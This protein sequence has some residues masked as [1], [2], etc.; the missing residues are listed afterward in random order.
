MGIW[1]ENQQGT[2]PVSATIRPKRVAFLVDKGAVTNDVVNEIVRFNC[3]QWGGRFNPIIPTD[4]ASISE[5]WWKLLIAVDPDIIY[6]SL[7][8]TDELIDRINRRI[9]PVRI[10]EKTPEDLARREGQFGVSEFDVRSITTSAMPRL[11][12][13]KRGPLG[14]PVFYLVSESKWRDA[15][16]VFALRNFGLV[17]R[18]VTTAT[19]F[20]DVPHKE[21]DASTATITS[22][23]ALE[24]IPRKRS[25][26]PLDLSS[27]FA[28][29]GFSLPYEQR[30]RGFHLV[31]GDTPW[32]AIYFWNLAL[33]ER[34]NAGREAIWLPATA[35]DDPALL[36][37][38]GN[39]IAAAF[40]GDHDDRAG[41]I[42]SYS[43][44]AD[45]LEAAAK[46][47]LPV[48]RIQLKPFTPAVGEHP[49]P[50]SFDQI[51]PG[52]GRNVF[53]PEYRSTVT[54][55]VS[56]S[57]DGGLVGLLQPEFC[58]SN[59]PQ[60]GWMADLEIGYRPDRF[61]YTN[62]RPAWRLP[63]RVGVA[64]L[65]TKQG[66]ASGRIRTGGIPSFEVTAENHTLELQIP[67]DRTVV[68]TCLLETH[69][70]N[71]ELEHHKNKPKRIFEDIGTSDKGRHVRGI[72]ELFGSVF[73]AGIFFEDPY[74]RSI[75]YV[76]AGRND[77]EEFHRER[78]TLTRGALEKALASLGRN[79]EANEKD[80][81]AVAE[82][83]ADR[84]TFR[85]PLDKALT[86]GQL[87]GKFGELHRDA[88]RED[89][90]DNYWNAHK[91]F[92]AI[93][94]HD[95]VQFTEGNVLI[96]GMKIRCR[97]CFT[98][99]WYGV[100]DLSTTLQCKGCLS[101]NPFP[102]NHEWSFRLNDLIANAIK[103]HGTVAVIH[104]LY[105][106][107]HYAR[108][109]SLTVFLPCQDIFLRN[110]GK[111]NQDEERIEMRDGQL[112]FKGG[113]RYSDLDL[114]FVSEGRIKL[115]EVKS[116]PAGFKDDDFARLKT[117]ASE[118]RPDELILAAVG[119][120]W[121]AETNGKIS[122]LAHDLAALDVLVSP[123]LLQW[124]N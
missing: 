79:F 122:A 21:I 3:R 46:H 80:L 27:F 71:T 2:I 121:S 35:I 41:S 124:R 36:T 7:A 77:P 99:T 56:I 34:P 25:I 43:V 38:L 88:L 113:E 49:F 97:Q 114:V 28:N 123:V 29:R 22:F 26:Y 107:E 86:L 68:W 101:Q 119:E 59:Q 82:Y 18:D 72:L 19:M 32:E 67:N 24:G 81:T 92:D 15:N 39:W 61:F 90:K 12:W 6:A 102:V 44:P 64:S 16:S 109:C 74:W 8:L 57:A 9:L 96:Q 78:I 106:L 103:H 10:F 55:Q 112:H 33:Q 23:L 13:D 53:F 45:K 54:Q 73:H 116:D 120:R 105:F 60:F 85:E 115:G 11:L 30:T 1:D 40:W 91:H 84:L 100:D 5:N 51:H 47:L 104:A 76:L 62:V 63:K 31:I 66:G 37:A 98:S 4:G 70:T 110:E 117:I 94:E 95:L 69:H 58:P 17:P 89:P 108:G 48:A 75:A 14:D 118:L 50:K 42:V 20:R 52:G 83:V 93:R 65:L 111:R 87:K